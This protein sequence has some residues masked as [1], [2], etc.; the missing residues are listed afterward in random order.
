MK[1]IL[2]F[3]FK[4]QFDCIIIQKFHPLVVFVFIKDDYAVACTRLLDGNTVV[5]PKIFKSVQCPAN[6]KG[7]V[8][9]IALFH[10]TFFNI[11]FLSLSLSLSY[12][13]LSVFRTPPCPTFTQHICC[14]I[15]H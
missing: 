14:N 1:K 13:C 3:H 10:L 2:P 4:S 15:T 11:V 8:G 6:I 9:Y 7:L 5:V 12:H